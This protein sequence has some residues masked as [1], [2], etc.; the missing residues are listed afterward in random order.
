[1]QGLGER[2][3]LATPQPALGFLPDP[4]A[5]ALPGMRQRLL[6]APLEEGLRA[7]AEGL[8]AAL[9]PA[10]ARVWIADPVPWASEHLRV[11]GQRLAPALRLRAEAQRAVRPSYLEAIEGAENLPTHPLAPLNSSAP[12]PDA[13]PTNQASWSATPD[14]LVAEVV[15]ARRPTVLHQPGE[16]PLAERWQTL[17]P[18]GAAEP[19][20]SALGTLAAYPLLARGRLLGVLAVGTTAR[21]NTRQLAAVAELADLAA[22]AADRDQL[23]RYSRSQ[24]ALAQTVVRHAP[25]AMAVLTGPE[26]VCAL[27]NPTFALLL[28]VASETDLYGRRLG[29]V[30][31]ERAEIFIAGL[32]LRA[33]LATGEPQAMIEL[34]IHQERGLTYWNV[35]TSPLPSLDEDEAGVLIAAVEVT[36]QVL[37]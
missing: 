37:T 34:P 17:L 33:V 30:L 10:L 16:H 26:H 8:A 18:T 13:T 2:A 21:L 11:G 5:M 19:P 15:A 4:L 20:T 29:E 35:T 24:E 9:A 32:R 25:V 3:R 23:L 36:R 1:V 6:N 22:L 28:G 12:T 31:P 14:P 27:A 7:V